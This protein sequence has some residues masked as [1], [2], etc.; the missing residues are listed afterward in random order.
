MTQIDFTNPET[1]VD[2]VIGELKLITKLDDTELFN[3]VKDEV[4]KYCAHMERLNSS[5]PLFLVAALGG[6]MVID[7]LLKRKCK[8]SIMIKDCALCCQLK[9]KDYRIGK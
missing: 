4:A 9:T 6:S 1:I 8:H 2:Q 3:R 5:I 7:E